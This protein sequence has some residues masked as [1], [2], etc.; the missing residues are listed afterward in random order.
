MNV[1]VVEDDADLQNAAK[2][3]LEKS[4]ITVSQSTNGN[5]AV[6]DILANKPDAVL[7]DIMLPGKSGYEIIE[8]LRQVGFDKSIIIVSNLDISDIDRRWLEDHGITSIYLKV[9]TNFEDIV[10][11]LVNIGVS[12]NK[13]P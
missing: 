10:A 9:T 4:D 1:H 7:L 12:Q 11:E 13:Q 5:Q 6:E 3:F 8:E 2:F